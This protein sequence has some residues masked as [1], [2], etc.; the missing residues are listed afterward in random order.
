ML[1]KHREHHAKKKAKSKSADEDSPS[2]RCTIPS[3]NNWAEELEQ[4]DTGLS[5]SQSLPDI[6]PSWVNPDWLRSV[7]MSALA[8]MELGVAS[9]TESVVV[10]AIVYEVADDY[11]FSDSE[12][13][14]ILRNLQEDNSDQLAPSQ[15]S[16]AG[17]SKRQANPWVTVE[18]VDDVDEPSVWSVQSASES[19][20]TPAGKKK[21]KKGKKKKTSKC[22][23]VP[24][25]GVELDNLKHPGKEA[26]D[27]R[28]EI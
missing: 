3:C 23:K 15:T 22:T 26:E 20:A 19:S 17:P 14:D 9:E 1:R 6:D 8:H 2:P 11:V 16:G 12:Y 4:V 28:R 5:D 13:A 18:D 25:L 10:N 27:W 21:K 24:E 7:Y